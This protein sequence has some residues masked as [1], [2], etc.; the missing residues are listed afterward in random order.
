MRWVMRK[1]FVVNQGCGTSQADAALHARSLRDAVLV[2]TLADADIIIIQT[3]GLSPER[4]RAYL[5]LRA[6]CQEEAPAAEIIVGGCLPFIS[7]DV[8]RAQKGEVRIV[9]PSR[10]F[11]HLRL[12]EDALPEVVPW[13]SVENDTGFIRIS[14]GCR[15]RCTYCSIWRATGRTTSR[16]VTDILRDLQAARDQGLERVRLVSEDCGAWGQDRNEDLGVL[17]REIRAAGIDLKI[18]I[19]TLHPHWLPLLGAALADA[20]RA[21][22]IEPMLQVP[23]QSGSNRILRLMGRCYRAREAFD[24]LRS[25]K[26]SVPDLRLHTDVIVGFPT[27]AEEDLAATLAFLLGVEFTEVSVFGFHPQP[28]S[29]ASR[30]RGRLTDSERTSRVRFLVQ[31]LLAHDFLRSEKRSWTQYARDIASGVHPRPVAFQGNWLDVLSPTPPQE[32]VMRNQGLHALAG[33]LLSV[34][35]GKEPNEATGNPDAVRRFATEWHGQPNDPSALASALT[36]D[37]VQDPIG[38]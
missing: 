19:G 6:R 22:V 20:M 9:Q 24:Q 35:D 34:M 37:H 25:L 10:L 38:S 1:V 31:A 36:I 14:T 17:L 7:P 3:C 26:K 28:N 11:E 5:D 27:E 15:D 4:E 16:P 8:V 18:T 29:A 23:I 2:D 33:A 32:E 13:M 21:G 12:A 30:L